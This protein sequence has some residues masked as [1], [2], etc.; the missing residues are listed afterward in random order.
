[1]K[2]ATQ[3][4]L[5]QLADMESALAR[6]VELNSFT[7]NREGGQRVASVLEEI[8]TLPGLTGERVKSQRFADHLIF[9]SKGNPRRKPI[10]LIGHFDTVFPPGVF[11]G[12]RVDGALRRG[13]GVLDMKGGLVVM[14]WALKAVA[15]V[16]D[17]SAIA[18]LR[19]LIVSDEEVGSPEGAPLIELNVADC[20]AALVFESG[21]GNDAIVTQRKGTG[22]VTARAFGKPAH[23]GNAYWEGA[24]AIWALSRFVDR[25]QALSDRTT[26]VTVNV[27]LIHGGTS[28]N[29]VPAQAHA[30][31]DIRFPSFTLSEHLW[32]QLQT[33]TQGLGIEG[34]RVE[35]EPGPGRT[36]ME[37]NAGTDELLKRYGACA[38]AYGLSSDEA[39]L[40]GGGSDGNTVAALGIPTIDALG[41]RGRFFH[42][43]D[44]Y[45]EAQTLISRA[46]ALT[47][48]LLS[49]T[50]KTG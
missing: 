22:A 31:L 33:S 20:E 49:T 12:Y 15:R 39:P 5:T 19:V 1:M 42:T 16:T 18:P 40:Q 46:Q 47:D 24:S 25:A 7:A 23:A 11:E 50:S 44:E 3:W 32:A 9:R 36:P 43:P 38:A 17:F 10:A 2:D 48:F 28:K 41:P 27:G 35:L 21:R 34:T 30:Q 29:T 45:I 6:L 8:F 14:A 26:G 37:K 4:L 13:P